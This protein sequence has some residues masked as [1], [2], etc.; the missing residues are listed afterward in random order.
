MVSLS[1]EV[2]EWLWGR[3]TCS[4]R[5]T[6]LAEEDERDAKESEP[7]RSAAKKPITRTR[8]APPKTRFFDMRSLVGVPSSLRN[9][10]PHPLAPAKNSTARMVD[11]EGGGGIPDSWLPSA[12]RGFDSKSLPE[13]PQGKCGPGM[14][15]F[16]TGKRKTLAGELGDDA[17]HTTGHGTDDDVAHE[18]PK[19]WVTDDWF[20]PDEIGQRN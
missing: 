14:T 3:C 13:E 11:S 2:E 9:H 20:V 6:E 17:S 7:A 8:I 1:H 15:E 10:R 16:R 4:W 18:D 5:R 12:S 19:Q